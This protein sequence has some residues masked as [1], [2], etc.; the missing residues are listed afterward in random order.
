MTHTR[1][2]LESMIETLDIVLEPQP[3]LSSV[4]RM[5]P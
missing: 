4:Q 5:E 2:R 3:E 1:V